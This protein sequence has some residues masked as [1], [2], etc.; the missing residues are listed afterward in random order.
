MGH[1]HRYQFGFKKKKSIRLRVSVLSLA[2]RKPVRTRKSGRTGIRGVTLSE[3][4]TYLKSHS[5]FMTY[6]HSCS[7]SC[8]SSFLYFIAYSCFMNTSIPIAFAIFFLFHVCCIRHFRYLY[9]MTPMYSH[10]I[11]YSCSSMNLLY[12]E[13]GIIPFESSK[14]KLWHFHAKLVILPILH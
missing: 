2:S 14:L 7:C 13:I 11:M 9:G 12:L 1:T 6:F 8:F 3:L 4:I 10:L 5:V